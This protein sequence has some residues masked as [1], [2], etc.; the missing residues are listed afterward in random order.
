MS[1]LKEIAAMLFRNLSDAFLRTACE[2]EPLNSQ[3]T[4]SE[5]IFID[6]PKFASIEIGDLVLVI[7][8]KK[9]IWAT[10]IAIK[11]DVIEAENQVVKR[12]WM[13]TSDQVIKLKKGGL[14][15]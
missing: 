12:S 1:E 9:R 11:G 7:A 3:A 6:N 5:S 8:Q 2:L 10:V 14:R 15:N 13:G 4:I